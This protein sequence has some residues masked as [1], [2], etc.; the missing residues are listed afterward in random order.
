MTTPAK[1]L[2][3]ELTPRTRVLSESEGLVEYV[4]S[5]QTLDSYREIILANGWKFD[6]R[7]RTNPV[8]VDSHSYWRISDVLGR[9]TDYRVEGDQLIE[10]VKWAV[11]VPE[12]ALAQLGFQMTAKGYLKAVSVGFIPV[13]MVGRNDDDFTATA[14]AIKG[15]SG[16]DRDALRCIFV[17]QQQIE[18]SACVLGANP[19]ALAKGFHDGDL[20]EELL[21]KCGLGTDEAQEVLGVAAR[22]FDS[23]TDEAIRDLARIQL[24]N[25]AGLGN[26][27]PG[28]TVSGSV[29]SA[30]GSR[31]AA[32]EEN[33]RARANTKAWMKQVADA[34]GD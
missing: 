6:H 13:K 30:I 3:R 4:A 1:P 11:D 7:F 23:T 10:V 15:L 29:P 34:L 31:R 14:D 17:E 21:A 27:Y 5:D 22:V 33:E 26:N 19:S 12:N 20:K 2:Y 25:V 28:R 18:L 8:F 9:V 32:E 16:E 24:R